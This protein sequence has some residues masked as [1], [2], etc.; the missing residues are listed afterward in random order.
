[1][2]ASFSVVARRGWG[3]RGKRK[4]ENRYWHEGCLWGEWIATARDR[5]LPTARAER[6]G[7]SSLSLRALFAAAQRESVLP[8]APRRAAKP[9]ARTSARL[10]GGAACA[11]A[12]AHARA[13][14]LHHELLPGDQRPGA[15][16]GGRRRWPP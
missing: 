14:R 1:M 6:L 7:E 8:A 9:P 13:C 12:S 2:K 15:G 3:L 16:G 4:V 5:L 11:A 10:R